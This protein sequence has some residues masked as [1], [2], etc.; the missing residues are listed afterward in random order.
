MN[1]FRE[2]DG[3]KTSKL[4]FY[5][6]LRTTQDPRPPTLEADIHSQSRRS[7]Q[8]C[9]AI[10]GKEMSTNIPSVSEQNNK[11]CVTSAGQTQA[12][13]HLAEGGQRHRADTC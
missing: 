8:P 9:C 13:G 5:L 1:C 10:Y 12:E 3:N 4:R 6:L 11:P 7:S 2:K